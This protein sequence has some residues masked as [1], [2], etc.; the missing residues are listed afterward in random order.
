MLFPRSLQAT[1]VAALILALTAD[2]FFYDVALG[3]TLGAFLCL[4]LG[5][6]W[7]RMPKRAMRDTPTRVSTVALIG[8]A[9]SLAWNPFSLN[10]ALSAAGLSLL[11]MASKTSW[12][13][14][15]LPWLREIVGFFFV[16]WTQPW[17][18]SGIIRRWRESGHHTTKNGKASGFAQRWKI[19][20]LI[21]GVFFFIFI[22]ANPLLAKW[23][24][25]FFRAIFNSLNHLDWPPL[26]RIFLWLGV[27]FYGW[28]LLRYRPIRLRSP[29]TERLAP[30]KVAEVTSVATVI[31][32]L[33][34]LNILFALM[35]LLDLRYLWYGA[36][37]P[38][39]MSYAEY[40]QR[41]AYP[42]VVSALL[43]AFFVL[44]AFRV[45][46]AA[47]RSR[48]AIVLVGLW[49]A[50][51]I[52]L[53]IAAG[54]RL[55][56]Y[57][58]VYS[59]TRLRVAAAVWIGL[60]ACGLLWISLRIIT[61]KSND[62][63]IRRNAITL[64]CILYICAFLNFDGYIARYNV[65]R[66]KE[67][68]GEGAPLDWDYLEQFGIEALPILRTMPETPTASRTFFAKQRTLQR[69]LENQL[70]HELEDW[71][72]WTLLRHRLKTNQ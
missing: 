33:L 18:D 27:T 60:V 45:G 15:P 63:L 22:Q 24:S 62:W 67:V 30:T 52:L 23:V 54:W 64:G 38:D 2:F 43:A 20:L 70:L 53:T 69:Q 21:S 3:W 19:P 5:L 14:D 9:F 10:I 71:Q 16:G 57:I 48:M 56:I 35:N 39:G 31:R 7:L 26:P 58:D 49:V 34:L 8:L 36:A 37:L 42:L 50:Q 25:D 68:T 65:E 6:L 55:G 4:C 29:T 17:R 47:E 72:S 40:A 12:R 32:S 46:G 28:A 59:L 61:H 66:C 44:L 11:A 13:S 41:G 51:N 1:A